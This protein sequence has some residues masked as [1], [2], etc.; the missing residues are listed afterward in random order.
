MPRYLFFVLLGA[1]CTAG[2]FADAQP[3]ISREQTVEKEI[4]LY[5]K[6]PGMPVVAREDSLANTPIITPD[7]PP[8]PENKVTIGPENTITPVPEAQTGQANKIIMPILPPSRRSEMLTASPRPYQFGMLILV[9]KEEP[10]TA[11][12]ISQSP[13]DL[14]KQKKAESGKRSRPVAEPK[15]D[16]SPSKN[17]TPSKPAKKLGKT[18]K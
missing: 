2:F 16:N 4:P 1:L 5:G 15:K 3:Q 10:E 13:K 18:Q 12:V 17:L 8:Q 9:P 11:P 6:I 7:R 14:S